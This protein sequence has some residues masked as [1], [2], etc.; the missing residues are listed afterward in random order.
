[1]K[2]DGKD[3]MVQGAGRRS[4]RS[5]DA[6]STAPGSIGN[7]RPGSARAGMRREPCRGGSA[8]TFARGGVAEVGERFFMESH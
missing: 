6:Y 2:W 1:M 8:P 3:G 4:N 5:Q 7:A